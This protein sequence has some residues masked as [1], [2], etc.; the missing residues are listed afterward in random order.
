MYIE[1]SLYTLKYNFNNWLLKKELVIRFQ[2]YS[3]LFPT[4]P[5]CSGNS[6]FSRLDHSGLG[7]REGKKYGLRSGMLFHSP[8]DLIKI[9]RSSLG[10]KRGPN[11]TFE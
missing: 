7:Y 3:P 2:L 9:S 10:K 6:L 5:F 4:I 11:H 8:V 1:I